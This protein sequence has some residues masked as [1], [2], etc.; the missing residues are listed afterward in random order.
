MFVSQIFEECAEILGTTDESKIFRKIQQAVATLMESGHWTHSVA[1]VDVCTGWDRCSI[2]LPRNIDVPLAVNIDGSPTY[3]RNRLFQYHVNKGGMFNSVEWAWDD[4]GYVATL[5]DIIQPSQLV[6]VAELEND[7]GKTIR[8]LG[9]D[10]NNRTLRSQLANGTGVDGLLVPIH[11]QSDFAYGTIT[12]DD[13]TVKTRSVAITPI[14]LFTSATAHGLSSGQGMSVTAATGTIPVALENGQTYYI[15]VI[16]A[17][18][19]QLFNDPLNAQALNYPINLQSIVGAGNLEFKD[20]RESQVVTALE[21][22]QEPEFTL[23]TANQITFPTGQSLPPPLNSNQT[24]YVNAVD[25]THLTAFETSDD[26]KKNINPVYTTGS[27]APLN[28]DI[29]KNI[30]PQT[31]LTFAVRHY[32]NDGDQVQAYTASGN[33]PKPLIAN[34]NYFVNIID[35]FSVSLHE[36][37]ADAIASDQTN[38]VNPIVLKDSGSGTNSLVKLI[39]A[40]SI[41]GTKQQISASGLNIDT[42]SGTGA[43]FQAVT[44]GSVTSVRVVSQGSGYVSDPE[45]TFSS[46]PILPES[47]PFYGLQKQATGYAIRDT[48]NNK[49]LNVVITDP[50]LGYTEAPTVTIEQPV[51]QLLTVSSITKVG[52][53]DTV[54]AGN[55]T[56]SGTTATCIISSHGYGDGQVVKISGASQSEYNGTFTINVVNSN[57]FTYTTLSTITTSPATGTIIATA[58]T[59]TIATA[60]T[61]ETHGYAA[62]NKVIIAGASPSGF[63]GTKTI[64]SVNDVA[65][66]F[67]Y[68]VSSLLGS[69]ATGVSITS[70]KISG[71]QSTAVATITKSFVSHFNKISGGYGYLTSP[72][73]KITGGGG[74]GAVA[75]AQVNS[76]ILDVNQISVSSGVATVTTTSPHGYD[77]GQTIEISDVTGSLATYLNGEKTITSVPIT[78]KNIS[79]MTRVSGGDVVTVV[80]SSNHNYSTGDVVRFSNVTPSQYANTP[81]V[82]EVYSANTFKFTITTTSA[83]PVLGGSPTSYIP[84]PAATTFTFA[85]VSAPNGAASNSGITSTSGNVTE[86]KAVT[87]GSGYTTTPIVVITPST[88]VF[89]SFTSTGSLPSP[90]V[91]GTAYR[92]EVPLSSG[93]FTVKNTDFSDV[94]ITSSG[95]GTFYVSLSRSFSVTFNNNWEGD[96][97]NLATGQQIYF[98]T[99]YLLPSTNPSIDNGVTPF[100]LN[101]INNTTGK[102]Y[103]AAPLPSAP[104][105]Y[106]IAG[107]ATGLIAIESFG[108]GQTYYALRKSFRSL[109]FG[110]LITPSEIAFLNEDQIVGFSTTNTLPSP[111]V[112]GTDYTIKLFGDS[113]KVYLGGILQELT[114]PGTGQLS[115][116]ILREF[117]VSP[118]TS[119]DADQAHFNTGDA[120][121]PRAKEGDILPTGLTAGTTYYARRIDNNSFELYDT[122][123]HAKNTPSTTG[124]NTYTTTGEIVESTFFV[125]SVTLPTFVKSV[126]QI[127][128]PIT[129]GYVSLYAYD[130]GRS[131]DMTLIGQ[132][133]PSEVNPQYRR[134]RIGKPCAWARISY[135]IQTPSIT[136]I[137]DFIPLEQERAI[138][139]AVH[140]CDLEDKDFADQSARYWQIAFSYLKNQ[141]ES[142]D[143]HAMSVPQINAICYGDTSD[144]V[145]F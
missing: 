58:Y 8:V 15:G 2:T 73:V 62:G 114:T 129:E 33:L 117:N 75:T 142:I 143:G 27:T 126:A 144:P 83:S 91:A 79:S 94:N 71:S 32:Y 111:L 40:T 67:T 74:S 109:P 35:D 53:T 138:I 9:N 1:D 56:G 85:A 95:T 139:T 136:S 128:K 93:T 23:E 38:L 145:M 120:V 87:A 89:V 18:T 106:A 68:T 137:Y 115:L 113:I 41:T 101:K 36:N 17:Y 132:Y 3:F 26:A 141:Q 116:D 12:P 6:A 52:A 13:A 134:I 19:V 118:S 25:S 125:D 122:L 60:T 46:P 63:N 4:R 31:T 43:N 51:Q 48:V 39:P 7:V 16:D 21:L 97:T 80:T 84:N 92:A 112:A 105:A 29:R 65:K 61:D 59:G 121:V 70:Q 64:I 72:Q 100:Y 22:S 102:I 86:V 131:N 110:N 44:I 103:I 45:V 10:Q 37:Q 24:Y 76:S 42:P 66:T 14:N 99:D 11:S 90:L 82:V 135:R 49:V 124:R 57:T 28:V 55:L 140:A 127:D 88:G 81:F 30:D 98:G 69:P 104:D 50:G 34:Q 96:F 77:D 20:T 130:Y 47:S 107:G 119:I 133:H 78:S 54:S 5:M 108:A 123:A